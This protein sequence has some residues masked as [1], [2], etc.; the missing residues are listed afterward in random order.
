MKK[1]IV[2]TAKNMATICGYIKKVIED[3]DNLFVRTA[4]TNNFKQAK[5]LLSRAGRNGRAFFLD[6]RCA[7]SIGKHLDSQIEMIKVPYHQYLRFGRT[8]GF[9]TVNIGNKVFIDN[10][11]IFISWALG[12]YEQKKITCIS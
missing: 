9:T 11:K 6:G 4:N 1:G 7:A 5:Q 2:V 12:R 3:K 8:T 10:D